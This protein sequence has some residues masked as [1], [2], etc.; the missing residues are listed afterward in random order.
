MRTLRRL[1][2]C[3]LILAAPLASADDVLRLGVFAYR[4]SQLLMQQWQPLADYLG[5]SIKGHRVELRVLD[6]DELA[7]ALQNNELDFLLTNPTHFI[8]LREKSAMIGVV[9]TLSRNEAGIPASALGGVIIRRAER[10][11]IRQLS[12]LPGKK[13]VSPGPHYLGSYVAQGEELARRQIDIREL[14]ISF[15]GQPQDLVVEAVLDG[16]ADVGFIRTGLLE[17]MIREGKLAP[18]RIEAINIQPLSGFPYV[19][20]TRLYPEWPFL[21]MPHV[22]L[23]VAR[24]AT[25]ALLALTPEHAAAKAAGIQGFSIPADYSPVENAMRD[26]R[27]APFAS[28]PKFTWEDVWERYHNQLLA[29]GLAALAIAFLAL[30]LS[31]SNRNLALARHESEMYAHSLDQERS[32][33][34]TLVQ[35]LPDLV[36]LK[37]TRGVYMACNPLFEQ[38][39]GAKEADIVGKTDRDF[40]PADLADFFRANDLKALAAGRPCI[41]EEWITMAS[42]G[43]RILLETTKVPMLDS[44]GKPI[45]ILGVG[46]D[47]TER[48]RFHDELEQHRHHLETLVLERTRELE[49]ARDNAEAASQAKSSFLANMSHEI[50]TPLNAITG[51][52]Y[53]MKRSG[54]SP[55]QAERL[56]K[57][58][59]AGQHL[60]GVINN[61]LD[62]SKIEADK[63]SLESVDFSIVSIF[64]NVASMMSDRAHAK[65]LDIIISPD[66]PD[67]RL[68]GDMTRLQQALLN[69]TSNA[70]KFTERGTVSLACRLVETSASD[71]LVRFEVADTG[72]GIAP[73]TVER[74][75]AAFEQGDSSTTRRFGGT[76]LGLAITRK[77]AQMMG[78][79]AGVESTLGE[80]STFWFTAR[81]ALAD[82]MPATVSNRVAITAEDIRREHAGQRV[83]LVEDEPVNREIAQELLDEAGLV[84]D[85]ASNGREAVAKAATE[86]YDLI[87]MDML[88]PEMDGLEATRR[89]R[90][91]ARG[92]RVPILAITANSFSEDRQNCLNAGMNDFIA[93]PVEPDR[94][95]SSLHHWLP[96]RP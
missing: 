36:W 23:P 56:D 11:D 41:N 43:R 27:L 9:A 37:D 83:L 17:S 80:G 54:L 58:D 8:Q 34:K 44:A 3:L 26:L 49:A 82:A 19:S 71:V 90:E 24:Q 13:I 69:Y 12:D 88:M 10:T 91:F 2:C 59:R 85:L 33:L 66:I 15:L 42:D 72:I 45:G 50:R 64:A 84:I 51:L 81:L 79:D 35:T 16:R 68:H 53:V 86:D 31:L 74:L 22:P 61:I 5:K 6:E 87:L 4:P 18:D 77:L 39:F 62:I 89:I 78:G 55:E 1:I 21:A 40:V 93:K 96:G 95:F 20:S 47:I 46:H 29:S 52:A 30:R 25:V 57:I 63:Y 76:G 94:L 73:E 65:G 70:V 38:F 28:A 92:R 75:F 48:K 14:D 32:I 60:L 67:L 7:R